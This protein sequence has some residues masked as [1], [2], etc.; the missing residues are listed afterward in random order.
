MEKKY[1]YFIVFDT[2]EG[3][4]LS[5]NQDNNSLLTYSTENIAREAF[6]WGY[7]KFHEKNDFSWSSGAALHWMNLKPFVVAL[8][9]NLTAREVVTTLANSDTPDVNVYSLSSVTVRR[10][11]GA[12]VDLNTC[13][14]YE[15]SNVEFINPT[16]WPE[17]PLKTS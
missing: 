6:E 8:D 11:K 4:Y 7:K 14:R 17:E 3:A 16:W 2:R 1:N 10:V 5:L 12:K 13:R 15:V 9:A